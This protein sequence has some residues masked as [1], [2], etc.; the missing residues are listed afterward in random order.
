MRSCCYLFSVVNSPPT[1][2]FLSVRDS[3]RSFHV[4]AVLSVLVSNDLKRKR[5][6]L[7]KTTSFH[8]VKDQS[9]LSAVLHFQYR[10]AP[11]KVYLN[12]V[13]QYVF[14]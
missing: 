3:E 1:L 13:L 12:L 5:S 14:N 9:D 8:A 7:C 4:Y 6:S 10:K 2:T 11:V